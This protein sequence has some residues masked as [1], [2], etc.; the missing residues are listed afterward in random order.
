MFRIN[1]KRNAFTL[2]EL[3]AVIMILGAIIAIAIPSVRKAISNSYSKTYELDLK[4]LKSA[5]KDYVINNS[6][7]LD[8][9]GQIFINITQMVN[10]NYIEEV[11]DPQ[12]KEICEGYVRVTMVS[13]E[14][15]YDPYLKCGENYISDNYDGINEMLPMV[16]IIGGN[17]ISININNDYADLGATAKDYY[18]ADITSNIITTSTVDTTIPGSYK[19]MYSVIDSFGNKST[20]SRTVN[21]IDNIGPTITFTPNG[22]NIPV[23]STS[24][25]IKV[26]DFGGVND[27]DLKYT[28][29]TSTT[30]PSDSAFTSSYSANMPIDSPSGVSGNYYLWAKATDKEGNSIITRSNDFKIDNTAPVITLNGD[31]ILTVESGLTYTDLGATATDNMDGTITNVVATSAVN[32]TKLGTYT[33]TYNVS[34]V[35]GNKAVPVVRQVV[36]VTSSLCFAFDSTTGT[37]T[38]YYPEYSYCGTDVIIPSK[39]NGYAVTKLGDSSFAFNE[40]RSVII[41]NSITSIG[42]QA[43]YFDSLVDVV[44]PSS[45]TSLGEASFEYNDL[46]NVIIP[47]SIT[48]IPDDVFAC[49]NLTS[50]TIPN[51]I[52]SVGDFAFW[53]NDLTKLTIPNSVK[54]I[55]YA[56]FSNNN[57]STSL[58]IPSSVTSIGQSAFSFN[59][60]PAVTIPNSITTIPDNSFSS[61]KIASLTIPS[62]V[63]SIGYSAFHTNQIASLTIPGSV[64]T[65]D[66]NAFGTNKLTSVV[67]PSGVVSIGRQAFLNNQIS[68]L[69]IPSTV[70]TIEPAAFNANTLPDAQAFIYARNTDGSINNTI[71]VSYG[72]ANKNPVIPSTVVTIGE[73]AFFWSALTG[74]TIPNS[75]K[76]IGVAAFS[77]SYL[78]SLTIP[79]SVASIGAIAFSSNLLTTLTI[80][81]SVTTM[82]YRAFEN[83]KLTSVTIPSSI[84]YLQG[85]VFYGNQ[86]S[87]IAIPN[88]VT[89]IGSEAFANNKLTSITLPNGSLTVEYGAFNNNLLPDAKAFIYRNYSSGSISSSTLV[90][91]GGTNKSIT[92]PSIVRTIERSALANL[93]LT[94]VVIQNGVTTINDN[95]FSQNEL[96]SVTIPNSVTRINYGAFRNNYIT[97]GNAKIDNTVGSVIISSAVFDSNGIDGTTTITPTYL[98]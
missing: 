23:K 79:S 66:D 49:N 27:N 14:Y 94:S 18:G 34:D 42:S 37:I 71:L 59:Y 8:N 29:S 32:P 15:N 2:I 81:S 87:S 96:T 6:I 70:T 90:S 26:V 21:V 11:K 72:S 28:W 1:K 60:I 80:P 64:T 68:S 63:T 54:S 86:L 9:N 69:T 74:V 62:G 10:E 44:I 78:T 92:I 20:A 38:D 47:S 13:D 12:T 75:V 30:A 58:T 3:I 4:A 16:S 48:I 91:Y 33:V 17:P 46:E 39:I 36:I 97:Q 57:I 5:A 53:G 93:S 83:N 35:A 52:T 89:Q 55:G 85:M 84:T 82:G 98:R 41:P 24:T 56:T 73:D 77:N 67:I 50:I 7:R 65:I 19:V 43:F 51:T 61:N 25:V 76:T 22:S 45:V 40:L 31:N 95:A 88:T